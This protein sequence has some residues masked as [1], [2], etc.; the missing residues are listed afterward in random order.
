MHP[1]MQHILNSLV[2][3]PQKPLLFHSTFFLF[4]FIVV[5]LFYPLVV[6]KVK[7][8]TWYLMLASL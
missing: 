7:V 3:D 5:L 4:F 6:N 8:R 2:Y 1:L